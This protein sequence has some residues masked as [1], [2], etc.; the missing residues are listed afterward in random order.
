MLELVMYHGF[1]VLTDLSMAN[2]YCPFTHS[3]KL[4]G[5]QVFFCGG[6][7]TSML[8]QAYSYDGVPNN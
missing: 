6:I 3:C 8:W 5:I 2:Q 4:A 7:V 1:E